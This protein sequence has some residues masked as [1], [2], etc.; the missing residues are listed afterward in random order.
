MLLPSTNVLLL[1]LGP[2]PITQI[3]T[4]YIY[5]IS[6]TIT[7]FHFNYRCDMWY[8]LFIQKVYLVFI[9]YVF[10]KCVRQKDC[11]F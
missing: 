5:F 1:C 4:N 8:E 2:G 10:D 11:C 3:Q 7:P 9:N 6:V